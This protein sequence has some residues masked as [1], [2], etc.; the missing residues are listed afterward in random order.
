MMV[1]PFSFGVYTILVF[2]LGYLIGW[3][4]ET[5][6]ELVQCPDCQVI[7]PKKKEATK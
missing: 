2:I 4:I 3:R 7:K 1:E 5:K 6:L